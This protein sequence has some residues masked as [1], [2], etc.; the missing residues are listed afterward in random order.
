[1]LPVIAACYESI[2]ETG[3]FLGK[4]EKLLRQY[5]WSSF[6][7]DRYKNTAA[8]RAYADFKAVNSLLIK[9]SFADDEL[10]TVPVLNRV[11]FPLADVDSLLGTGWPKQVRIRAAES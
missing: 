3:D 5:L 4:G 1:M 6:F 11:E 7:T 2:P 9:Q 10:A 8:S